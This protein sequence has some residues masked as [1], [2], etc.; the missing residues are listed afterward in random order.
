MSFNWQCPFCGHHAVIVDDVNVDTFSHVFNMKSK[1]GHQNLQGQVIVCPNEECR[2]YALFIRIVDTEWNQSTHTYSDKNEVNHAWRLLPESRV[3]VFPSYIPQQLLTD[4]RE[5][6][7]ICDKSPKASATLSR[8]CLQGM[9]RDFWGVKKARLIDEIEAIKDR[10]D[11][12]TWDAIDSLR[13]LGNIGA[14]MEQD[15]NLIVDVDPDEAGLLI[16]LLETLFAEWYVAKHEREERM[17]RIKLAAA[18]KDATKK[19]GTQAGQATP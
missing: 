7:L 3:R 18:A 12:T 19:N 16:D 9:M 2:E 13:R 17:S 8:R 10:V 4:Y 14:H 5:A 1:Y 15:I 6:C 11:H